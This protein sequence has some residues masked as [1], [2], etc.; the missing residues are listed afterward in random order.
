MEG[1]LA[2][3]RRA[4]L[5]EHFSRIGDDREPW[6]VVY[7]LPEVLLL[8]VCAT[9]AGCDD[10]DEIADWGE[11]HLSFLR[12]LSE[13]YHG[14]PCE[15]WLRSLMN[16]IDP[17]LFSACFSSWVSEQFPSAAPEMIAIDGKTSR[18][19]HDRAAGKRA[20]HLV[21]AFASHGRLVLGQEAVDE[22][23]NEIKAIPALL[24]RLTITGALVSIDAIAC[25]AKIAQTILDAGG[26]YLLAVK[27]NQA[28]LD[29]EIRS[30]FETAP[31]A[32][33]QTLTL[34]D[35]DHGRLETRTHRLAKKLDWLRG[36]R[37]YPGEPR[38][39]NLKAIAMVEAQIEKQGQTTRA[40]R[41]YIT[42]AD[43]D[44]ERLARAVRS[45]WA[46]ENSL[47]WVLDVA[48]KE[49]L[50][51]LR[52]GHGATNMAIVRP[53]ALN[54]VR[55]AK[56]KRSIKTR[57]KRAGWDTSYLKAILNPEPC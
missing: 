23:S 52:V 20:L 38:F 45:H 50:S 12:G 7:P 6:R 51:R 31:E 2:K 42:S 16:R 53:F 57:R 29:Q 28:T 1:A 14:V 43:L 21:S 32:E 15:D 30:Y 48:F 54:L 33:L 47:H 40:R 37:H 17:A 10:Y 41:Y 25:N 3:P 36:E 34:L 8:A 18:R 22:K 26:D 13:F 35:K 39:P 49:D 46:I 19:S 44:P 24:Q 11:A 5:L 9:I 4:S 55:P 56:D 27:G